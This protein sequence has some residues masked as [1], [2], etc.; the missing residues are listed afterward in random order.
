MPGNDAIDLATEVIAVLPAGRLWVRLSNGHELV[1]RVV[2][3]RQAEF[4]ALGPGGRVLVSVSPCDF[5]QGVVQKIL[6]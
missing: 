1:A 3:R 4:S 2:R 6:N 5:S